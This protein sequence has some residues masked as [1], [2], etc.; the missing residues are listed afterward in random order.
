MCGIFGYIGKQDAV[1]TALNGLKKLEYRG[2]DSAGIAGVKNGKILFCKEVGKVAALEKEVDA[3][4]LTL[5]VAITQT[6]WATHGQ[7]S[8]INAHPH[9]DNKQS[10]AVVH[11]GIIENY[12]SLR[13]ELTAKGAVFL[14]QTDTEVIAHLVSSFYDGD[15]LKAICPESRA[16]IERFFCDCDCAS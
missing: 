11:N 14:S 4:K 12:E 15:F 13:T 9:L 16:I 3:A 2:Y 8:K 6:R 5:D 1:H 7:P 10:L